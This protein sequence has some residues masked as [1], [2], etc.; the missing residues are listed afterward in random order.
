MPYTVYASL[1]PDLGRS[2]G[3]SDLMIVIV[4]IVFV[5]QILNTWT[6]TMT[7]NRNYIGLHITTY[8]K[9]ASMRKFGLDVCLAY[10]AS[11]N[12]TAHNPDPTMATT[13]VR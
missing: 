2:D 3:R 9:M 10:L 11:F 1:N 5:S 12:I 6:K 8:V 13:L 7:I 4:S